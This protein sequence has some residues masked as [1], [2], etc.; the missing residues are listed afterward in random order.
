MKRSRTQMILAL[1]ALLLPGQFSL[2]AQLTVEHVAAQI[3]MLAG[4]GGNVAVSAGDDGIV[5]IDDKNKGRADKIKAALA[6]LQKGE[7]R[8]ILNTHHHG[9][10]TGT[11]V[12]FGLDVPIIAHENVRQRLSGGGLPA[13]AWPIITFNDQLALHFNGEKMQARHFPG[14]HTDGDLIVTFTESNVVAMGDLYFSG[15]F[16]YV[17]LESGGS[18]AGLITSIE[19]ILAQLPDDVWLIPGHGPLSRRDDLAGYLDMLKVTTG[20][21]RKEMSRDR[22]LAQIRKKGLPKKWSGWAW[23]FITEERWIGTVYNSYSE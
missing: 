22:S 23:N 6:T 18:V 14:S 2:M 19:T 16:P 7:L 1:S 4:E 17:D 3:Y 11:N 15:L 9:D 21:I 13:S 8:Y 20:T 10:H 5:I 12:V